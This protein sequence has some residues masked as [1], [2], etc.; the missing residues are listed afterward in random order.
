MKKLTAVVKDKN[1]GE[2][3]VIE[4]EYVNKAQFRKD[5]NR[6]GY[7]VIGRIQDKKEN[8]KKSELYNKGIKI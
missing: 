8:N 6:N 2:I 5:L 1:N 7:Q 4:S 3:I